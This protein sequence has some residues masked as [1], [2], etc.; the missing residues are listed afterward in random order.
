[1]LLYPVQYCT[2]YSNIMQKKSKIQ[3][4]LSSSETLFHTSD[5]ATIWQEA[6]P[7][8]L[9]TTVSRYVKLGKLFRLQ[10][11]LY[12]KVSPD[13]LDPLQ[14]SRKLILG[15]CYLSLES[16]LFE[17]GY[18]SQ[19]PS[20]FT[21]VAGKS[22]NVS[23]KDIRVKSH[24]M[25]EKFL[26]ND[27]GTIVKDKIRVATPIRALCDALYFNRFSHFDKKINWKEVNRMQKDIGFPIIDK[28]SL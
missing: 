28:D 7:N 24:Q 16:V 15:Y 22:Q 21:F 20:C 19:R 25:N 27:I 13:K 5:L 14:I 3:I 18:R 6:S 26:F 10:K 4:L 23:W 17:N 2:G 1:M 8:T 11:G 9:H 12:S